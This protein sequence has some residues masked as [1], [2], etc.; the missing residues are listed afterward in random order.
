MRTWLLVPLLAVI[1]A[2]A[3][4]QAFAQP[5]R[6]ILLKID[7][8]HPDAIDRFELSNIK[9]LRDR[10]AHAEEGVMI[11]PAHP[12]TGAYGDWHTTSFPN[13]S[14]LAGTAFLERRPT[15]LQHIVRARGKTLHAAGSASYRS[16][17][18]G[19]HY[20]MTV[21]GATDAEVI[22][23]VVNIFEAS[24]DVAFSRIMLQQTG[25][26][27][28]VQ[29]GKNLS[30]DPWAQNVFHPS[31]PFGQA[32][33]TA[34]REIGRLIAFLSG[35]NQLDDTLFVVMG[36]GQSPKGW[37]LTLD[38]QSALTP[39]IFAGPGVAKGRA[40]PYAE[41]IDVAPT[42]AA[43][44]KLKTPNTGGGAGRVLTAML[45]AGEAKDHPRPL[46]T[47]N[48]QIRSYRQLHA[49]ALLAA[50]NDP[51]MNL[52]LMELDHR[53]LSEHQ[54]FTPERIME[55]NE[56][57][58]LE[59]MVSANAWVLETLRLALSEGVYRFGEF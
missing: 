48:A 26:A 43:L 25:N 36:D 31:S 59:S 47:I 50:R 14:T 20:A 53:L 32:L 17:N 10:G 55:W 23:F 51:K 45:E 24:G 29:S 8:L 4:G 9:A 28:R 27:G 46:K 42:I 21:S 52:L 1:M 41:N 13:V 30:D 49:Q 12:T 35:R 39:I 57:E 3:A 2:V 22:D 37:H 58:D 33:K 16:L 34:D 56:A 44:M 15:F 6:T 54:F 18:D 38:E 19:F 5:A 7:G 40:I 11:Y